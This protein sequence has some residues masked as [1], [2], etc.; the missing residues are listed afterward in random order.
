VDIEA[1]VGE[2]SSKSRPKVD[3]K[4]AKV[5]EK[6]AKVDEKSA[7]VD[8]KSANSVDAVR[9]KR[10]VDDEWSNFDSLGDGDEFEE[11]ARYVQS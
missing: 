3:E 4:S 8:E 10:S 1:T 6:S 9:S 11:K 5:D 7:K 2:S